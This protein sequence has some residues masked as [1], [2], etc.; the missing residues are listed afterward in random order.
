MDRPQ[1]EK[2]YDSGK[3]TTVE[4]LL[5]LDA[6]NKELKEKVAQLEKSS[7]G[8]S[9]PPSSDTPDKKSPKDRYPKQ[10]RK[11]GRKAG[12]QQGHQKKTDHWLEKMRLMSLN[13]T[14]PLIVKIVKK[15]YRK[16]K[17]PTQQLI[18]SD[19]KYLI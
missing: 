10:D 7:H 11:S 16:M 14:M 1:A 5:E 9:K 3:E 2:L 8:S 12:G 6:E 4:R 15:N 18:Y 17:V 13:I 19:G